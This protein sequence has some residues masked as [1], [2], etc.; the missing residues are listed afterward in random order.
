MDEIEDLKAPESKKSYY[1]ARY[2]VATYKVK[3]CVYN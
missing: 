3:Y 2:M 1:C